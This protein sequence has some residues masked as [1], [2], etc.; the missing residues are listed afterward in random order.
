M[1]NDWIKDWILFASDDFEGNL[2]LGN[3]F[4]SL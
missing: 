2:R 4:Y 1:M 3:E